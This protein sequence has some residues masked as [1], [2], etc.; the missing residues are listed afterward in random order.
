MYPY[1]SYDYQAFPVNDYYS[2]YNAYSALPGADYYSAYGAS[3]GPYTS[4]QLLPWLFLFP[5]LFGPFFGG[6]FGR[7]GW[8]RGGFGRWGWGRRRWW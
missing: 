6:G 5:F 4:Q 2:P 7:W 3:S 8:G 1:D